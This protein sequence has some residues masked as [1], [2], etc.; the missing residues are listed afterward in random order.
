MMRMALRAGLAAVAMAVAVAGSAAAASPPKP[1][2]ASNDMIHFTLKGPI[3]SLA[4]GSPTSEKAVKGTLALQGAA[5]ET[6]PVELS[7][8]GITRRAHDVCAFPPIRVEFTEKPA[9]A[10]LFKGQKRLKLVTHCR[11]A[12]AFQQYLLLE[13]AAY[14]MYSLL[15]PASF[16]AR[17]AT[18]D[19]VDDAGKPIVSRLGFFIEDAD[20][21]AKRNDLNRLKTQN[22][23]PAAQLSARDAARFVL[24]Q[25]MIG[26]L[27]WAMT[28]GPAGTECCHNSRLIG[29]ENATA[30]LIPVPYDFD[31]SGM[32]DAPYATPPAEIPLSSVRV[33]RYRGF[34][35]HNAEVQAMAPDFLAHRAA[36]IAVLDTVPQLEDKTKAKASAY[37]SGFF[38]LVATPADVT[39]LIAPCLG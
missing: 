2:F 1:L 8:R 34:C 28:A 21:M 4:Q 11:N 35:R 19:Y 32:V 9:A 3:S 24:F 31:F 13:Y 18:V 26:N 25:D 30:N 39:K 20:D 16:N 23:V 12:P 38:D 10:S 37:L 22:R 29:A 5:P 6:L 36:F 33:R 7:P 14:K 27:D 15:T 17:L